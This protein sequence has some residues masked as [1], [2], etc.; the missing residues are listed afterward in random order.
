MYFYVIC[1]L[2]D[3]TK[4]NVISYREGI[5]SLHQRNQQRNWQVVSQLLQYRSQP[6]L[7][8]EPIKISNDLKFYSFDKKYQ[9]I[10]SIWHSVYAV[11]QED[12][13]TIDHDSFYYLRKN[14]DKVPIISGLDETI[15]LENSII[16]TEYCPN[17][18]FYNEKS[19]GGQIQID[20][21]SL[22]NT[23]DNK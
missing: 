14:F 2:F 7:I 3:I 13:Y 6:L 9:G 1:T 17:I 22:K 5:D 16:D 19:W 21:E 4:T 11:A 12:L 10:H 20:F 18:C 15:K 8:L 23:I